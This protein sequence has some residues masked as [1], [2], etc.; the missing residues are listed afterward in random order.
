[1]AS[2]EAPHDGTA[3]RVRQRRRTRA[4]I[5]SAA[6][7]LLR[8]GATPSVGQVAEAADVSRRTVSQYFPTLEQLLVDATLGL[9]D[10]TA[11]DAAIKAADPRDDAAVRVVA[12]IT[13][14]GALA[15][16]QMSLG[17]QLVRLTG[18]TPAEP[19]EATRRGYRRV[20]WIESAL[21]PCDHA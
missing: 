10:Q 21:E 3:T 14:L 18:E 9:L 12:M 16:E 4:A 13:A 19:P 7:E 17:R 2:P 8:S 1:M 15:T 6:A 11:V 5:V 20:A